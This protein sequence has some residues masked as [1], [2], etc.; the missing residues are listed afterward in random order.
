M[1]CFSLSTPKIISTG[2]G[3]FIITDDDE[4]ARKLRMIKNFGRREGGI[5][6]F[7]VFGLNL[8]FT[9]VQG[10]IGIEQAKKLPGRVKRLREIY[11]LYA[12]KLGGC[13]GIRMIAPTSEEWIPWF[14]DIFVEQR[15]NLMFFLKQHNIQTRPT[16]PE[17]NKTPMYADGQT[18]PVSEYVS[19]T[20]LFLPTH[21]ILTN[22]EIEFICRI[23]A[24]F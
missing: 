22:Q 13:S 9:D 15:E 7:E 11:D 5:D 17:I 2:Q 12:S 19:R 3:G 21:P 20:G 18:F 8:K 10:V 16:Y 23:L 6:V 24:I 1:G 4:L 14:V